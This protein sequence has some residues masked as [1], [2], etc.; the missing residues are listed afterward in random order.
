MSSHTSGPFARAGGSAGQRCADAGS[1]PIANVP[2]VAPASSVRRVNLLSNRIFFRMMPSAAATS[3]AW[4]TIA[5]AEDLG[6]GVV[7]ELFRWPLAP[8]RDEGFLHRHQVRAVGDVETVAVGPV[9]VYPTPGVGPIVIDLAAEHVPPDAPHV[10]VAAELFQIMV[11]HADIVDVLHLEREVVQPGFLMR[12]AEE[13]VM[14][15]VV[16]A[17]VAAVERADQVVR[18]A[19]IDVVGAD[20]SQHLAIPGD[21]LAEFRRVE[22]AMAD[23]LDV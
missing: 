14:V 23:P 9:L 15:D 4:N 18:I 13:D 5:A 17:A 21:G 10:L 22:H 19:G 8:L 12:E 16:V 11:A 3:S 6:T 20:E 2:A 1:V 7:D